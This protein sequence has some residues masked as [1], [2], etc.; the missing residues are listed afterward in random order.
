MQ[1]E[2]HDRLVHIVGLLVSHIPEISPMSCDLILAPSPS[3]PGD[4]TK[5]HYYFAAHHYGPLLLTALTSQ[6][7]LVSASLVPP[8]PS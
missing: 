1:E 8:L 5:N 4:Y 2:D 7:R 6:A 3:P